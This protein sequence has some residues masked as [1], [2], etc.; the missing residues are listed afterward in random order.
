MNLLRH[1]RR[2][3]NGLLIPG[4]ASNL[5]IHR[6]REMELRSPKVRVAGFFHLILRDAKTERVIE[7]RRFPNL[8][9]NAGMN[10]MGTNY[11]QNGISFMGVGSDATPPAFTQTAL[12][13]PIGARVSGSA[14]N[15]APFYL[16]N[17]GPPD[18]HQYAM[19]HRLSTAQG[20]GTIREIGLFS[21]VSGGTMFCRALTTDG[22]GTP[23]DL[24]KTD[25]MILDVLYLFRMYP[26]VDDVF[27]DDVSIGGSPYD[28]TVRAR[29]VS[30]QATLV[31]RG[32][33]QA[34]RLAAHP[35]SD[36]QW[37]AYVQSTTPAISA[38]DSENN[39]VA[40]SWA[41]IMAAYVADS[42]QRDGTITIPIGSVQTIGQLG[43]KSN[44]DSNVYN[45]YQ[46]Q[47]NPALVKPTT[48][49]LVMTWR[50]TWARA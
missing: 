36:T 2:T 10:L 39:N 7:E 30:R 20:N 15:Q 1:M 8:I 35:I 42:H 28:I 47:I 46:A 38:R 50:W 18:Y 25:Q 40:N 23:T 32:W 14:L 31:T 24:V 29:N 37:Y 21:A 13:A 9:T 45:T 12:V 49:Q 44:N 48:H 19:A 27:H 4:D 41:F 17:A 16:Y 6:T 22:A 26:P 33:T 5:N 11:T 3:V 34:A 43:F